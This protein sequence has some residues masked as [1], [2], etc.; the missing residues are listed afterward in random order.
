MLGASEQESARAKIFEKMHGTSH[1]MRALLPT[2]CVLFDYVQRGNWSDRKGHFWIVLSGLA[3][4][5]STFK[6]GPRMLAYNLR[7]VKI[8]NIR[9]FLSSRRAGNTLKCSGQTVLFMGAESLQLF[10]FA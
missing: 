8:L 2:T 9:Q 6:Q 7:T 10:D 4:C 3:N 1:A 5:I